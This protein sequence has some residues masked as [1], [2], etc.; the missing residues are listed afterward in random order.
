MSGDV[1]VSNVIDLDLFLTCQC[2]NQT[3]KQSLSGRTW[4]SLL[5][6]CEFGCLRKFEMLPQLQA[7]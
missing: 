2:S 7:A 5:D 3:N 4:A 1:F 6:H